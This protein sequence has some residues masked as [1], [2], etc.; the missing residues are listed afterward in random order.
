MAKINDEDISLLRE[1]ADIVDIVSGYSRLKKAGPHTFKALCPFHSE[2]TP[3]F[4]VDGAKGLWHCLAGETGVMTWEGTIPIGKLAGKSHRLLTTNGVWTDGD[5]RSFGEQRLWAVHLSRNR[6]KKALYATNGHRWLVRAGTR[7]PR[8]VRLTTELRSGS[9]LAFAY[10]SSANL[11]RTGPA[12]FGVAQGFTFGDGCRME[13]YG[14]VATFDGT[15]D[16]ELLRF[17][18]GG[19]TWTRGRIRVGR[20]PLFFKD[21]PSLNEAPGYLYG[22]LAGY[23]AADGCVSTDGQVI[24]SCA[25]REILEFVRTLANR[26]GIGT[27]GIKHQSR[28]GL[29]VAPSDLFHVTFINSTLAPEFFVLS[30][31]RERFEQASARQRFERKG[32]VVESVEPTDRVEEVFCAVVP[33]THAF[34]LEDNILT[35]NCFGCS[36][37]GDVYSF[38]EKIENLP[39]PEAVEWLARRTGYDLRYEEMRPGEQVARGA[40]ARLLEANSEAA[41]FWHSQLMDSPEALAARRYLKTRGFSKEVAEQ[42][43]L[44]FAPGRNALCRHLLSKGFTEREITQADLGRRSDRDASVYDTFRSRIVFPTWDLQGSVVG[45][46]ARLLPEAQGPKYLNSSETPVFSKSRV[47]YGLNRAKSAIARGFALVVEG[48]TDVIALHEA[49]ITEAV[50]TN[51]V[52]L[53]QSHFEQLKKFTQRIVLMLD[54]DT[55]GQ[56]ATERSFDIH[57]RL[58]VE[59]LVALLPAGNDPADVVAEEGADAIRKVIDTA[60]PILEFKLEQLFSEMMLDTPEAKARAVRRASQVLGW[61]PDPIARHEYAF[62]AAERIGVDAD[63]VQR[64]LNEELAASGTAGEGSDRNDD[65]RLPGHVKVEREALQ[66]LLTQ[67]RETSA[68]LRDLSE[69]DFTSPARR[70]VFNQARVVDFNED[71]VGPALARLLSPEARSLFTELTVGAEAPTGDGLTERVQ[72]VFVRIKVFSLERDIKRRRETLQGVNPLVDPKR[73]DDLF[74]Q[75]VALEAERRDLL[76]RLQGA[77]R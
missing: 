48:Y 50:A 57:H 72:E 67:T 14:S 76:R 39:F 5:I 26:L 12:P 58:G 28:L 60:Q 66:L 69:A 38:V 42:W 8:E 36:A 6:V 16:Q 45:F 62:R 61:H 59:V 74:T 11:L 43:K 52:A 24:L 30:R 44:G 9:R 41:A 15:K 68:W 34:T 54:A 23:F 32:W 55:A 22:W 25:L 63:S 51:G 75:L 18:P 20:L 3:S 71:S 70:E 21:L 35:G 4:T 1:R 53:G 19:A 40:K 33:G 13:K 29:G 27:Y 77:V 65:R 17:F 2:K 49:G 10:P 46:G 56:G 64:A 31:H 7:K 47:M 37:G 73:H